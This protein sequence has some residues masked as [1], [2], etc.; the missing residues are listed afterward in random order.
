V[1]ATVNLA[2]SNKPR[3]FRRYWTAQHII[4]SRRLCYSVASICHRRR[5]SV[6]C[7]VMYCG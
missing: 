5:L 1:Q 3:C 2:A 7:D 6:V 4:F